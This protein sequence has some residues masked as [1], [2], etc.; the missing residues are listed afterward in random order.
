M[1]AESVVTMTDAD[2]VAKLEI[3]EDLVRGDGACFNA[4]YLWQMAAE[5]VG[6][7]QV[8][9]KGFLLM[10]TFASLTRKPGHGCRVS[11]ATV[12]RRM[13]A[14]KGLFQLAHQAG[15]ERLFTIL[16]VEKNYVL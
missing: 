13:V 16:G 4:D 5:Q 14:L 6:R 9:G 7:E 1:L 2:I 8:S 10:L 11:H 12:A 3:F 15:W